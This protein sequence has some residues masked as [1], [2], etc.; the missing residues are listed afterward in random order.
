MKT[1]WEQSTDALYAQL[2]KPVL[3]L[4][5]SPPE[6]HDLFA[7]QF[8]SWK[9]KTATHIQTVAPH[10]KIDWLLDSIHDVP[11][12]RPELIAERISAFVKADVI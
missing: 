3:F 11:L 6:S 7:Q 9:R 5:C 2:K 4:P 12:Q 10:A 8:L 1:T